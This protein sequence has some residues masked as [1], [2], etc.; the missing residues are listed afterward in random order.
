MLLSA[1]IGPE[2]LRSIGHDP[3]WRLVRTGRACD[4]RAVE[5]RILGPLEVRDGDR[6]LP[7]GIRQQRALLALLLLRANEVVPR[8]RLIDEL[9]GEQPPRTAVKALQGH[10]WTLRRLVEPDRA[11]GSAGSVLVT[12]GDGY[13]LRIEDGQLDLER[14][15][16]LRR[17]GRSALELGKPNKA[18]E[19]LREAL[20][21]WRGPPLADFAY[22]AFA[23]AEIARLEELRLSALEDRIDADLA[24]GR[25]ADLAGELDAL[26]REHPLR[27]RVRGQLMLSLYRAGRQADALAVYQA[28]R[29]ALVDEL[30]IEPG[31]ALRELH[32]AILRQD[33]KLRPAAPRARAGGTSFVGRDAEIAALA[34]GLDV[35][36]AGRGRLFLLVGEPGIGKSRLADELV[37]IARARGARVLVGRAWE[38]GGAPAYWPWVQ[39]LRAHVRN[40][41]PAT[42]RTELGDRAA[43][44]AQLLPE[45]RAVLRDVDQPP[46]PESES[47]RFRLFEAV[48]SFLLAGAED[49]PI[50]V[51]LDDLH[52]AD[53][54]SLL[55]LRFVSRELAAGRLLLVCAFR[56]VDPALSESLSVTLAE[57]AREPSTIRLDLNGLR[58][59]EVAEYIHSATGIEPSPQ[60]LRAVHDEAEGNPLFVG[61]LVRLLE[62]E[63]RIAESSGR[64]HIPPGVRAVI[65]QRLGRLSERCRLSLVPASVMG[66]EFALEP[67]TRVTGLD[68]E[69][70]LEVLDEAAAERML[71]EAPGAPGRLRFSHALIRDTLYDELT[72]ARRMRLHRAVGEAIEATYAPHL[73]G[74]LSE[75]AQ[76]FGA[77]AAVGVAVKAVAYARRAGDRALGQLAFEE[78]ARL[79]DMALALTDEPS[80]RCELLLARGEAEARAGLTTISK[81]TLVEAAELADR[82]GMPEHLARA[83]LGYGGR[84]SWETSKGDDAWAPL[85]ERALAALPEADSPLRVW[86]LARLAGLREAGFVQAEKAA[87]G[88]D[89]VEM[90]RRL[91]DPATVARALAGLIPASESPDNVRE[92]LA[93][94]I[95]FVDLA[96][97]AGDK[98]RAL[99]AH[100]HCLYRYLELGDAPAARAALEAMRRLAAELRQPAQQWLVAASDARQALLEGRLAEAERL[101]SGALQLGEHAHAEIATNTFRHQLYLLRREQGRLREVED[102]V[103][104]SVVDYPV[105]QVWRCALTQLTAELELHDES[106]PML[107]A[108]ASNRFADLPFQE[109][110]LTSLS[111]LAEAAGALA[112]TVSAAILYELLHPYAD[113]VAVSAPE[114]STGA[115]ARYVGLVAATAGHPDDAERHFVQAMELNERIGARSWLAHTQADYARFALARGDRGLGNALLE[116]ALA[117][118][119]ELG[120]QAHAA[121]ARAL[122]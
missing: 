82:H 17:E 75:L 112:D 11:P 20:A 70:L 117:T 46:A 80:E 53:Q 102:L 98:E 52:V 34:S 120:M 21:L 67:L 119:R 50:V 94:S 30:G 93:L 39:A 79:Y 88:R 90:A 10:V 110:W 66:R 108:L 114:I 27:E 99:E 41:D 91:G 1:L 2:R 64:P 111:L 106:R 18:S 77:A 4:D 36:F 97:R 121:R 22:D 60:L 16:S 74:H 51:V 31:P 100:E 104:R 28:G 33:P 12:R 107:E 116:A 44:L 29:A 118:Y 85:L 76:H 49:H 57:L 43:E 62:A 24:C 115:V 71:G 101:I 5:F 83:A 122:M 58:E 6:V 40:S 86:L 78:A 13:E 69:E 45:I 15:E 72:P 56:N 55:L 96:H 105:N 92:M 95:E 42:L 37:A 59:R 81:H 14:F 68:S 61:E 35:A 23:E 7:L 89:G 19:L 84:L 25:H 65:G 3:V 109:T 47:A 87:L 8:D 32:Q 48:S 9:W 63:G 113:R 54:P 103:R 38:A 73:E 26:T